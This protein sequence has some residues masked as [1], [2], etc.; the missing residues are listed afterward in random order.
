MVSPW[1]NQVWSFLIALTVEY[2]KY[3]I[4]AKINSG[5]KSIERAVSR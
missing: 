3:P 1:P 5:E 2:E 4:L